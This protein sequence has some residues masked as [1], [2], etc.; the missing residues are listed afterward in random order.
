M[1]DSNIKKILTQLNSKLN[2]E[3]IAN[4][5]L[6]TKR[7]NEIFSYI[8]NRFSTKEIATT[9]NLSPSTI[10]THRKNIRRKLKLNPK[11][12]LF[13]FA[14]VANFIKNKK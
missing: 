11:D 9:L 1:K 10:E 8:G 7:E 13:E 2:P 3:S 14:L 4:V 12:K 5:D 6:L